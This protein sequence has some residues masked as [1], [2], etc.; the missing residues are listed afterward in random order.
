LMELL[1]R[2]GAQVNLRIEGSD[3]LTWGSGSQRLEAIAGRLGLLDSVVATIPRFV[4]Q[5]QGYD[6]M[7]PSSPEGEK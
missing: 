3:I 2:P 6:P 5:N 4:W 7:T 1:L